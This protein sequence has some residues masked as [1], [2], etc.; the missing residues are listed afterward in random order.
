MSKYF[1]SFL[2]IL[3]LASCKK[4][5]TIN[6]TGIVGNW[7]LIEVLA[8]P[9]DLSGTFKPVQS[10]KK[11]IFNSDSSFTCT[12]NICDMSTETTAASSGSYQAVNNKIIPANCSSINLGYSLNGNTLLVF[13]PCIE[14]CTSKYIRVK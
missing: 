1:A 13:Y 5:D 11:I 6:G 8:D 2:M 7:K 3:L 12:G 14:P 9:G 10:N 4:T